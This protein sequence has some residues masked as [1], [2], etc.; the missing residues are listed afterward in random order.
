MSATQPIPQTQQRPGPFRRFLRFPIVWML[1]GVVGVGLVSALAGLGP[2][3]AVISAPV[4]VVVYW[5][6]M[7]Y[8]AARR[9]PEIGWAR[10]GLDAVIGI[11]LGLV[12]IVASI[13]S[14]MTEFSFAKASGS[15]VAIVAT[16]VGIQFGGAVTEELLFRG[17]VLQAL[18]RLLGSWPALA[19][20]AV[21]FGLA[22]LANPGATL[23]TALAVAI[24]AG[25]LLGAAFLWRRSLWLAIGLHFAWNTA[26]GLLGT[27]VSGHPG[28]GL[29]VAHPTGP[30]LLT[31]GTFGIEGSILPVI[32]SLL[33]AVPML[34]LAHR[35]GNLIPVRP[36]RRTPVVQQP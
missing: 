36:S 14:V 21:L 32:L 15:A 28:H 25:V 34:I 24:E 4:A 7:R 18:E 13:L 10:S 9:T 8:V 29:L 31:G 20:T 16:T 19:I 2:V 27:P 22:H 17:L 30:Y 5:L 1:I 26:E 11:V 23:W 12:L 35:R 33:L 3:P 6:V